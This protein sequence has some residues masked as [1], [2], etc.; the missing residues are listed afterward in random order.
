MAES[1]TQERQLSSSGAPQQLTAPYVPFKTFLTAIEVLEQGRPPRLDRSVWPTLAG[2]TQGALLVAFR[3]LGLVR[4]D[5]AV[6][7]ELSELVA[8]KEAGRKPVLATI[9]VRSYS[10]LQPLA[11][12]TA[13]FQMLQ[14]SMREHGGVQGGTLDKAIRFYLEAS[15]FTG[16]KQSPLWEKARKTSG[17]GQRRQRTRRDANP[18]SPTPTSPSGGSTKTVKLRSGGSVTLSITV[19]AI[20]MSTGD[21]DWVF[22]LVD[23][24]NAYEQQD[25]LPLET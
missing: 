25:E 22:G 10:A 21:R 16:L 17:S 24:L 23:T 11:E 8:A 12:Q 20:S 15:L 4:S 18:A 9:L 6:T 2:T 13:S 1:N 7:G 19:D 3:F 14:N 5:G